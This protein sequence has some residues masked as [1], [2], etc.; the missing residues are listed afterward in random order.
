VAFSLAKSYFSLLMKD[1]IKRAAGKDDFEAAML[2]SLLS[3]MAVCQVVDP[4][5]TVRA[6]FPLKVLEIYGYHLP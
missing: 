2:M 5:K 1:F 6:E 4:L 3:N